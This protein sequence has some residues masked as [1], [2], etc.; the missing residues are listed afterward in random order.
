MKK[1]NIK[2]KITGQGK[3]NANMSLYE[4]N[5]DII[6]Q[7]PKYTDEQLTDLEKRISEWC[8]KD[9]FELNKFFMLLC[10][11]INYYTIFNFNP[12][13]SDFR[14]LGE[15]IVSLLY[16]T[17]YTIHSDEILD[18][19]CEIWVKSEEGTYAFM[20]FPYDQG[21]VYYG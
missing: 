7:L 1:K 21:V 15:G 6:S 2:N 3:L 14:F 13:E 4:I 19:H 17:G 11:D 9:D 16:D 18:D 8:D 20:L 12:N 5:Q 10:R